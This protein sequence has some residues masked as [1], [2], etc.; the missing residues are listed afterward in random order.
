[1]RA[2]KWI[3]P[4]VVLAVASSAIAEAQARVLPVHVELGYVVEI[5][6]TGPAH[7]PTVFHALTVD[8][9]SVEPGLEI[10]LSFEAV[11][12]SEGRQGGLLDEIR[13]VLWRTRQPPSE[14]IGGR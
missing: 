7:P 11:K 9:D 14:A 6:R 8:E 4:I 10:D 3:V 5:D 2:W 1:M 12:S 13:G